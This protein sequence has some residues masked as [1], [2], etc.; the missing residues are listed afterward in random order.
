MFIFLDGTLKQ[1]YL[2]SRG[3]NALT[4]V[5]QPIQVISYINYRND[6]VIYRLTLFQAINAEYAYIKIIG[7]S[8][9]VL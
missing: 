4:R 5:S 8:R 3:K 2:S 7:R 9:P 6:F 1:S